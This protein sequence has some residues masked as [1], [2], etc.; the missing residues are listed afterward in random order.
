MRSMN[1][2][3]IAALLLPAAIWLGVPPLSAAEAAPAAE[4]VYRLPVGQVKLSELS[5]P[6]VVR[7]VDP[8]A[9]EEA[10]KLY[11]YLHGLRAPRT[12]YTGSRSRNRRMQPDGESSGNKA[13][14]R[15]ILPS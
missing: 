9:S 2:K 14:Y 11:A 13:R 5:V 10:G 4:Q 12:F 3:R 1:C 8:K 15:M 7:L 6:P